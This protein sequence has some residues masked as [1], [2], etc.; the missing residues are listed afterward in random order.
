MN[1]PDMPVPL[2]E[3]LFENGGDPSLPIA[4]LENYLVKEAVPWGAIALALAVKVAESA[5]DR[6]GEK[7]I[8]ALFSGLFSTPSSYTSLN[9]SAIAAIGA[10][11]QQSLTEQALKE[12]D[13]EINALRIQIQEY[14]NNPTGNVGKSR[15]EDALVFSN[16]LVERLIQLG[17]L[18]VGSFTIAATLR[19]G[20]LL[21]LSTS[22]PGELQ[23]VKDRAKDY[24]AH[25]E[26]MKSQMRG[27]SLVDKVSPQ[28][29]A[30]NC[31]DPTLGADSSPEGFEST[32]RL[33]SRCWYMYFDGKDS[34]SFHGNYSNFRQLAVQCETH[35]KERVEKLTEELNSNTSTIQKVIDEW[36]K[37]Q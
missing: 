12:C 2:N 35:R 20:I 18:G 22:E 9:R 7:L 25:A 13:G 24:I 33:P 4:D 15:I 29:Y 27:L 14:R 37:L 23:N 3:S 26:R 10:V 16:R 32:E 34:R 30:S 21:E 19:L 8:D 28:C 11:I 5:A 36:K 17:V 6:L 31:N 1:N